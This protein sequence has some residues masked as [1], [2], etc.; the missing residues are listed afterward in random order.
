MADEEAEQ[1]CGLV[2][3]TIKT[4]EELRTLLEGLHDAVVRESAKS[5]KQASSDYCQ[6]FCRIL[7][8]FV[9]RW[10]TDE[11]PL[12]LV[13]MYL[14]A[15]LSFAKASSYLSLQCENVPLVIERL[16]LSFL[17]HLLSL[18]NIPHD[19]WQ[20][21]KS[22]VQIAQQKLQKN[23]TSELSLL[24]VLSQYGGIWSNKVLQSILANDNVAPEHVEEFLQFE[25]PVLLQMRVKQL[26][27]EKQLEKAAH[28]AK[29]CAERSAFQAKGHFK[30]MH[31][32]CLCGILEKDQLMEE[33]SK[34]DCQEALEMICN[35]E[36]DGEDAAAFTLCSAFLN[37]Q[38]LKGD[39]YCSWE[40]TLFW[41]KLLKRLDPSD[42]AFLDKCRQMSV[43]CKSMYH[44]LF[45]IKVIQ[46]EI[47]NAGLPVCIELCIRALRIASEDDKG[48]AAVCK[49]I[50]CLLPTDLEVKRACQLT[51]FLLEPTADS[52]Y[53]VE[54]LYNEPDQKLEE[55]SM[56]IPNSLRCE[57]L[58]VLKTQWPF[59]PEFW[60]W[61][62][63]KRHCLSLMGKEAS[64]ISSIESLNN[65][66]NEE[67]EYASLKELNNIPDDTVSGTFDLQEG[68]DR[69]QK[70][71]EMKKLREKG[72]V[73][74]RFR[75]W[76]A[77][78]QYCVLCDKEFLGHRI[79]R[80]AQTHISSG[81]YTCPIC[82]QT[83]P[84]KETLLPHVTSHVKLSCKERLSA[85]NPNKAVVRSKIP[86]P[87]IAVL[88]TKAHNELQKLNRSLQQNMAAVQRAQPQ[89]EQNAEVN[90]D[91]MCP[92]GKC[93]KSFKFFKNLIAHVKGHGDNEEAKT[94]LELQN[95]KVVCHY[96]RRHFISVNHLNDHLQ[97]HCGA[98]PYIC[99]QL[100]CKASFLTNTKLLT[101]KKLHSVFKARCMFPNCGKIF[102]APFKLYDHEAH[103]YKT[104]T[105]KAA[106]CGKIFHTQ[107]QL[108]LHLEN[109]AIQDQEA[110][111]CPQSA[112]STQP[113]PSLHE[114]TL[115]SP[116]PVKQEDSLKKI[117]SEASGFTN[118][119][120]LR[121]IQSLLE[122]SAEHVNAKVGGQMN[123]EA[124]ESVAPPSNSYS[125]NNSPIRS[126]H[127]HS[128]DSSKSRYM[129]CDQPL[130]CNSLPH[131]Y[132]A[133]QFESGVGQLLPCLPKSTTSKVISDILSS[134]S[135]HTFMS[136]SMQKPVSSRNNLAE[137]LPHIFPDPPMSQPLPPKVNLQQPTES[138]REHLA[139]SS[140][141]PGPLP[142]PRERFHCAFGPCTKNYS[143]YRS[144]SKHMKAIH[145]DFYE[146]WKVAR[147]EIRTSYIPAQNTLLGALSSGSALLKKQA[148]RR[149]QRKNIIQPNPCLNM[150]SSSQ[151]AAPHNVPPFPHSSTSS[152]LMANVLNSIVL[153]QLE[154]G[155]SSVT[156]H[157]QVPRGQNPD[158]E[159][160]ANCNSSQLF[161]CAQQVMPDM[162]TTAA[163]F[164]ACSSLCSAMESKMSQPN[165]LQSQLDNSRC[166][167]RSMEVSQQMTASPSCTSQVQSS[168]VSCPNN[169]DQ[170]QPRANQ[171]LPE[172]SPAEDKLN[173]GSLQLAISGNVS[174]T[175]TQPR[176]HTRTKW[177][178]I[179]KD[180]KFVCR[181]CFRQFDNPRSLG[182][183]LSKRAVCKPYQ[184]SEINTD[185]PQSFLD[186]LNSDQTVA[187][188]E[189]Q[190]FYNGA[191]GYQKHDN[192]LTGCSSAINHYPTPQYPKDNLQTFDNNQSNNDILKQLI[193]ESSMF[194]PFAPP[195]HSHASHADS[196]PLLGTSV[197]QHTETVQ[198]KQGANAYGPTHSLEPNV[199]RF[200]RSELCDPLLSE[201][202]TET[203]SSGLLGNASKITRTP[204]LIFHESFPSKRSVLVPGP[205][206]NSIKPDFHLGQGTSGDIK[207]STPVKSADQE[208]KKRL[209]EQIL[210]G[211]FHRRNVCPPGN[212]SP[213]PLGSVCNPSINSGFQNF[214]HNATSHLAAPGP[215][216]ERN[217]LAVPESSGE[218]ESPLNTKSFIGF[219]EMPRM[220]MELP[221]PPVT[222]ANDLDS[223]TSELTPSQQ[224]W[225]T[226]IQSAL[227][228]LD[229]VREMSDQSTT[230]LNHQNANRTPLSSKVISKT[231]LPSTF[232][233]IKPFSCD[234]LNCP[235]SSF[236]GESLWK[237]LSKVHNYNL[238]MVNAVKR[239]LGQYAPFKCQ[240]CPKS[241]TRNSNLRVHYRT[242]HKLSNKEIEE[243][244]ERRRQAKAEAS[245]SS[246]KKCPNA[247]PVPVVPIPTDSR[248]V[249][250][251]G[252]PMAPLQ[253]SVQQQ[254]QVPSGD[255]SITN[256]TFQGDN[257]CSVI[258]KTAPI[259]NLEAT[260]PSMAQIFASLQSA[261]AVISPEHGSKRQTLLPD[262]DSQLF[263]VKS[264]GLPLTESNPVRIPT[265]AKPNKNVFRRSKGKKQKY[266]DA[267]SPYRPYRCV[268]QG[269]EAAFTIQHNLI[270]HYKA[271]HQSALSALQ[272]TEEEEDQTEEAGDPTDPDKDE[273]EAESPQTTEFRCQAKDC[274]CVFQEIP[275]LIQHYLTL[276]EFTDDKVDSLLSGVGRFTCG[277]QGCTET[278][279]TYRKYKSHI[280]EQHK[281]LNFVKTEQLQVL[282]KCE[283]EGCDRSYATKSN[284]LRHMMKKHQELYEL[285]LQNK[286]V[287]EE[288]EMKKNSTSSQYQITKT[289]NGKEN[290]ESN[291]K[292][293]LRVHDRKKVN[294][295]KSKHWLKYGKPSLKSKVDAAALCTLKFPLQYPCM[296]KGCTSVM[297]SEKSI[298][299]HYIVHGLSEKYLEQHRSHFIFCKKF[300]RHK[301]RSVR[302]DDSK[303]ENTSEQSDAE[304]ATE[305]MTEEGRYEYSKPVL[306][307]R[308]PAERPI[309][310]FNSKLA[311]KKSSDGPLVLKRKRGRP[312]KLAENVGKPN[313]VIQTPKADVAPCREEKQ[314]PPTLAKIPE[315]AEQCAPLSSFKPMGFEMSFLKF[316]EQTNKSEPE[317]S[318]KA[319][320]REEGK[321]SSI[322][323]S[324]RQKVKSLSK[325]KIKLDPAF[326]G[327]TQPMLK[328]L[329]DMD[330][331]VVLEKM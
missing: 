31:L 81:V 306:R 65:S 48:K 144:V 285:K 132:P 68:T 189:L 34:E 163:A 41:S 124:A 260:L 202:L 114:Q 82:A 143:S 91:N 307:R 247:G 42:Q 13:Q 206:L 49:T 12:P 223:G 115:S 326:A 186:L 92:V 6:G 73:S 76:Q 205:A 238:E 187:T 328:Q 330:P 316:L 248:V 1:D 141:T 275:N 218:I 319:S 109:H 96:C 287:K 161:S 90:E 267:M 149:V 2:N 325:V 57:L 294:K 100:N 127:S 222:A 290:I 257:H 240:K 118:P 216:L 71:R 27:K 19:V 304:K 192:T 170:T 173:S 281:D 26:I 266:D 133:Q 32:V 101:H 252:S 301:C 98:K 77:Y 107:Q 212:G 309:S 3:N 95:N 300:S 217:S 255:K 262:V 53:V 165:P 243:L 110:V 318:E 104:F 86:A 250:D 147:S 79:V 258:H 10:K 153:S 200:P 120:K 228:R 209:R 322:W 138:N 142:E 246:R 293:P 265:E 207:T 177:P 159:F 39:T 254:T 17:E 264:E 129:V 195:P 179:I 251:S 172:L 224:Q 43:L 24:C 61:K 55:E 315:E 72:F 94:F 80:H 276:H 234:E 220:H 63:L 183:H 305:S 213:K 50:F 126:V 197:I 122:T 203:T 295:S 59:D 21:F 226:D 154:S 14:V 231:S 327:F 40:L 263:P 37:H 113:G 215:V 299:K 38:L 166:A 171:E 242:G 111:A 329:Q 210:A 131:N 18:K 11:E 259:H 208:I 105:C 64:I 134:Q 169:Q 78:M 103:H 194:D 244:D 310:R 117:N 158:G 150:S 85:M 74:T 230:T 191:A 164:P 313:K 44:I 97:V 274:C 261:Q 54:T 175:L 280:K 214:S 88:K 178:A 47:S 4:I 22:S 119:E 52:Y 288:E 273:P 23:G 284:M 185:L 272:D 182:G 190:P 270:L 297:K 99:I 46:S 282:F 67:E 30:Q 308:S 176:K 314:T 112:D 245:T 289:S 84:S 201:I 148:S 145:P 25:G 155:Q 279:T 60:D 162:D 256:H 204:E 227:E 324:N 9:G 199:K 225:M 229:L 136:Q 75:N 56:P 28:L 5:A 83:F 167:Q 116:S 253:G 292:L 241:F 219:R 58:L 108:D 62:T 89:G 271:V 87:P 106:D 331:A 184:E 221:S 311:K 35:L 45:L 298:L 36:S 137:S 233:S 160:A 16:S 312:K 237:H 151:Y 236:S 181:R 268:H 303:S 156:A 278:F 15:L 33:L 198:L 8:E 29:V 235:F 296:I 188:S 320:E 102:N 69:K 152:L 121:S 193:P 135:G 323:F 239:R 7:L 51:E 317:R 286:P 168:L 20:C 283:I 321:K 139:T 269:C 66:E 130:D 128:H 277:H 249:S 157:S 146:Q 123:P 93:K 125:S 302:S 196:E 180:G 232:R 174:E 70:N 291:K 140:N 211:D